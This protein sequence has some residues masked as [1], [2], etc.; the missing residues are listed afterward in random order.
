MATTCPYCNTDVKESLIEAE[1]GCCPEC[2]AQISGVR[3]LL[4]DPDGDYFDYDDENDDVFS[5]LDDED[6]D[7]NDFSR[8]DLDDDD[9]FADDGFDDLGGEFDD[10]MFAEDLDEFDDFDDEDF[11]VDEDEDDED[12]DL[13]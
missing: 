5:D 8:R 4:D 2:G 13:M 3:S 12:K 9:I 10:E 7:G 11:D 6:D 1:D